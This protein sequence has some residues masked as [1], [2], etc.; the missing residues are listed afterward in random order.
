VTAIHKKQAAHISRQNQNR[1]N[2]DRLSH[3]FDR[4][5]DSLSNLLGEIS[6]LEINTMIVEEITEE[7]ITPWQLYQSIYPLSRSYLDKLKIYPS[8]R[9]R[10]LNLRRQLEIEYLLLVID[11]L[12][13]L[14]ES[15]FISE[16][17][18]NLSILT[19]PI[20]DWEKIIASKLPQPIPQE[21]CSGIST[22]HLLLH[23]YNFLRS[24]HKLGNLKIALDR[25]NQYLWQSESKTEGT[26]PSK[27]S[28]TTDIIYAQTTLQLDGKIVNRYAQEI[29]THPQRDSILAIHGNSIQAGEKQWRSLL[30]FVLNL[31]QYQKKGNRKL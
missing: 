3:Q 5:L 26:Y 14:Y 24:L 2:S 4:L 13:G 25:R 16:A 20:S 1:R 23:N 6:A 9:D 8:L 28:L 17:K 31:F 19:Q 30:E 15:A 12:S 22:I 27:Q 21:D 18:R 11:P 10:Y 7:K 29:L